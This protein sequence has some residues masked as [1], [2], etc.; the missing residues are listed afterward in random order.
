VENARTQGILGRDRGN[1][2]WVSV[3]SSSGEDVDGISCTGCEGQ[4]E[5]KY[6]S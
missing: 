5:I 3:L 4:L 6:M 2:Q 1:Y